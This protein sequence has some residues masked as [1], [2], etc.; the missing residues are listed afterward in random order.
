MVMNEAWIRGD[1]KTWQ[2]RECLQLCLVNHGIS[3]QTKPTDK[4]KKTTENTRDTR[5]L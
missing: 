2:G 3:V 5:V 1:P 4:Y